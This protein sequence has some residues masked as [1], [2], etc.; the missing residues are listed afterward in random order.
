MAGGE[1]S[2]GI[3][4]CAGTLNDRRFA[5]APPWQDTALWQGGVGKLRVSSEP[6]NPRFPPTMQVRGSL[7]WIDSKRLSRRLCG[8]AGHQIA[9]GLGSIQDPAIAFALAIYGLDVKLPPVSIV[10]P[11][12]MSTR[13]WSKQGTVG[14]PASVAWRTVVK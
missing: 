12:R 4:V 1:K 11:W 3:Y 10:L 5:I 2:W 13:R 6:L 7:E 8:R 9:T 14:I